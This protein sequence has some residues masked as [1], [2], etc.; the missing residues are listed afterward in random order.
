MKKRYLFLIWSFLVPALA[1]SQGNSGNNNGN[2]PIGQWE[3]SGDDIN[4]SNSGNVGIGTTTPT[5]LLDVA[6]NVKLTGLIFPT[7]AQ[8]GFVLTT[9]GSG[10]TTWQEKMANINA[11]NEI[12]L[13]GDVRV[14]GELRIGLSSLIISGAAPTGGDNEIFTDNSSPL[15]LQNSVS[16]NVGIGTDMP[17]AKLDVDGNVIIHNSFQ[18]PFG[19]ATRLTINSPNEAQSFSLKTTSASGTSGFAI[20]DEITGL[21]RI[22]INSLG[23]VGIGAI[24]TTTKLKVLAPAGLNLREK[25]VRFEVSDDNSSFISFQ[26]GTSLAGAFQPTLVSRSGGADRPALSMIGIIDPAFDGVNNSSAIMDISAIKGTETA[27]NFVTNRPIFQV[28]TGSNNGGTTASSSIINMRV[29]ANGFTGIGLGLLSDGVKIVEQ[30]Q[31]GDEWTFHNGGTKFIG[32]NADFIDNTTGTIRMKNGSASV[33][34]FGDQGEIQLTVGPDGNAGDPIA[35][36]LGLWVTQGNKIG[37]GTKTPAA[38]LHL[39]SSTTESSGTANL[40]QV[41]N[42][43]TVRAFVIQKKNASDDYEDQFV[44][45]ADGRTRIGNPSALN[46]PSNAFVFDDKLAVDGRIRCEELKVQLSD[47]WADYVFEEG[48]E[49]M[50]LDELNAYVKQKGHLPGVPDAEEVKKEGLSVGEITNIQMQKIEELVLYVL[51]L[52]EQNERLKEQN[53]RLDKRVELLEN[54]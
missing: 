13:D 28:R 21:D 27:F 40:V 2:A 18:G 5:E 17:L 54:K 38:G 49:L 41:E 32:R 8:N 47:V 37:I 39:I 7:G 51:Q 48:Y 45:L 29:D 10:F 30:F 20:T 22:I 24:P 14:T 53:E 35:F 11:N 52:K 43:P 42:V 25:I 26:N 15:I 12:E 23:N 1:L 3:S 19:G 46:N 16:D 31:I 6:G 33:I 50:P 44:V 4:N 34:A 9:N 36:D